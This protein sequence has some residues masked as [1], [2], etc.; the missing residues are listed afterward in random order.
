MLARN[1][2]MST[3]N[4]PFDLAPKPFQGI[5]VMDTIDILFDRMMNISMFIASFVKIIIRFKFIGANCATSF[6]VIFNN[7]FKGIVGDIGNHARHNIPTTFHYPKNNCFAFCTATANAMTFPANHGFVGFDMAG[8]IV[9]PINPSHIFSDLMRHTPSRFISNAKLP[10]KFLCGDTVTGGSEKVH[11]IKPLLKRGM[12]VL[13]RSSRHWVNMMPAPLAHINRLFFEFVKFS[14]PFAL[15]AIQLFSK[16]GFHQVGEA[17]III[18]E[19]LKK[20]LNRKGVFHGLILHDIKY[21]H[22]L[23][24]VKGIIT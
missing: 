22:F 7:T 17:G 2:D 12:G 16:A 3:L 14:V 23:P 4:T 20:L 9:I 10:L 19:L 11:G 24:Y 6:N 1:V 15:R 5:N 8:Q 13:K 18:G 21:N